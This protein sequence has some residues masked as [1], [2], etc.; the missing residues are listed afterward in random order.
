MKHVV[1]IGLSARAR[2]FLKFAACL[3]VL[4]SSGCSGSS[5]ADRA[6]RDVDRFF[7]LVQVVIIISVA[8]LLLFCA[9]KIK[10]I[11]SNKEDDEG[12]LDDD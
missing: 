3:G 5:F 10:R 4:A 7:V 8:L 11:L 1:S 6:F 2:L 9:M 12:N